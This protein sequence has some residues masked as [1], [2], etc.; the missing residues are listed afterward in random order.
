MGPRRTPGLAARFADEFNTPFLQPDDARAAYERVDAACEA[1]DR[2]PSEVRR[3]A[4]VTVCCGADEP[5]L[6]RRAARIG[7]DLGHLRRFGAAGVPAE[8]AERLEQYRAAGAESIYLQVLDLED[9]E[10]L[11]LIAAEVAPL[12]G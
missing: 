8:L 1:I 3:S 5:E 7:Q 2:D 12:L 10:H 9:L 11:S 6:E 4:A